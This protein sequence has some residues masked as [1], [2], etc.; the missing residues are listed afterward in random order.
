MSNESINYT[1]TKNPMSPQDATISTYHEDNQELCDSRSNHLHIPWRTISTHHEDNKCTMQMSKMLLQQHDL[2]QTSN[3]YKHSINI[4]MPTTLTQLWYQVTYG[5]IKS[6]S[7]MKIQT[8]LGTNLALS[9]HHCHKLP[10]NCVSKLSMTHDEKP[11][12]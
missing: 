7:Y 5:I 11:I 6:I 9:P 3:I 2:R 8:K 1:F 4:S 10:L 12:L